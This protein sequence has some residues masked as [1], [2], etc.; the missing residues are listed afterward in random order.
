MRAGDAQFLEGQRLMV[1]GFRSEPIAQI[2][3]NPPSNTPQNP[4]DPHNLLSKD[5]AFAPPRK[6]SLP[7]RAEM[8]PV[9]VQ[10]GLDRFR[11]RSGP[12]PNAPKEVIALAHPTNFGQRYQNDLNGKPVDNA[13]IIVL[14]ETTSSASSALGL[15]Q[16]PHSDDDDQ[17]SYHAMVDLDGTVMY[18]VPPDRRAYG[19]ANSFFNQESVRTSANNP[20]SVNNFAYHISLV[21]PKDGRGRNGNHSGY[22]DAQYESLAW[23]ASKTGI[24]AG[25]MTAHRL[26]DRSG[27]RSDPRSFD[28][29]RFLE[30]LQAY[31][32]T[33]EI[34]L[35]CTPV[36]GEAIAPSPRPA[37]FSKPNPRPLPPKAS[38]SPETAERK[39]TK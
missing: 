1:P 10:L 32:A 36:S 24:P 16:T 20:P 7:T 14:H 30:R 29:P 9:Q 33:S 17:V 39:P 35:A 31:P 37:L 38:P 22:T 8:G 5:C 6:P 19:A 21:T 15:F 26:V 12:D 4:N 23:L 2:D 34:S 3:R 28:G 18:V 11:S 25:R 27:S 13:P